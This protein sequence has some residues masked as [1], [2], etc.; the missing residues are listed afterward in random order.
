MSLSRLALELGWFFYPLTRSVQSADMLS[1]F[2][3]ELGY[4]LTPA[5]ASNALNDLANLKTTV[6]ALRNLIDQVVAAAAGD[7][8][9]ITEAEIAQIVVAA[10]TVFDLVDGIGAL[11]MP[12]VAHPPGPD[13]PL[14]LL[15][16]L[17]DRYFANRAPVL[18]EIA[19]ALDMRKTR[20]LAAGSPGGR[21]IDFTEVRYDFARLGQFITD[22]DQWA[23]EVYGW[24]RAFDHAKA[25][26]VLANLVESF[27]GRVYLE[28]VDQA[29]AALFLQNIPRQALPNPASPPQPIA[30]RRANLPIFATS[31]TSAAGDLAAAVEAGVSVLPVGDFALSV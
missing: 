11:V 19:T 13:F 20:V 2:L 30:I 26:S 3:G 16:R 17:I 25:V 6:T 18:R 29:V 23:D 4:E 22:T 24:G 15:D 12:F 1:E 21:S 10:K 14:E 27:G 7:P 8:T 9:N 5:D 28:P 31:A